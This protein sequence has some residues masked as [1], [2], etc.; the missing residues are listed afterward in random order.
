MLVQV[1]RFNRLGLQARPDLDSIKVHGGMIA[2]LAKLSP[3]LR[4]GWP[5]LTKCLLRLNQDWFGSELQS[6]TQVVKLSVNALVWGALH[7]GNKGVGT[8]DA[9]VATGL[10]RWLSVCKPCSA[11]ST[12]QR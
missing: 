12:S 10:R 6:Q 9:A 1:R 7:C 11:L 4:F 5:C 3:D 2:H 8:H